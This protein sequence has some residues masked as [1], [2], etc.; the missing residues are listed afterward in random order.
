MSA[1]HLKLTTYFGERDRTEHGL[2][3]DALLDLYGEHGLRASVLLR[4]AEG[5]G[6]LHH[7]HTDRLLT[8]SED[9]PLVSIA[10][11]KRERIEALLE[12]VLEI[13]HRGL[14][15]LERA[16]LLGGGE[17]GGELGG[18]DL[19]ADLRDGV[20]LTVFVGRRER[21]GGRAAFAAV[22]ELLHRRGVAGASVL[23]G[24]DGTV[25]GTRTRARFLARN[26]EVPTLVVA[27]GGA[28]AITGAVGELRGMLRSPLITIERVQVCKRDGQLLARPHELPVPTS[29]AC[30]YGR[31]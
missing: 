28:N 4:G 13:K 5:F 23:L 16:E 30:A 8:L 25:E 9:L 15:T 18:A 10:L 22:T 17:L 1:E 27:V 29:T 26:A 6:R 3:A 21:V 11:D 20:K 31:S 24:V 12:R 19:P 2:L 14:V 7:L